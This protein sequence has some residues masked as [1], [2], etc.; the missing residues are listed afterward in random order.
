MFLMD[1]LWV[2]APEDNPP[3][4]KESESKTQLLCVYVT[5]SRHVDKIILSCQGSAGNLFY[6]MNCVDYDRS[7]S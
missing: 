1:V 4:N 6:F 5:E 7:N 2:S 3:H